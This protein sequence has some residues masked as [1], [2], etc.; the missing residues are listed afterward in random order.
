MPNQRM[1]KQYSPEKIATLTKPFILRRVKEDVLT[2]LPEKI[3][4]VHVS[5]LTKEQKDLYVG[6]LRQVQQEAS[7]SMKESGFQKNRMRILAGLTRLRQLCCHPSL[8][9][10]NYEGQS[11]KL[12]QLLETVRNAMANGK[13][14]LIFSQFTTMHAI[15]IEALK[16][17]GIDRS[18]ERRVGKESRVW[19]ER[20]Q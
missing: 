4:S 5:E 2:E 20:T 18:E 16:K 15:I 10:E 8:F 19:R 7:T 14:M 3:E 11:G 13:R 6:Y 1:F 17:E 12:E 9:I